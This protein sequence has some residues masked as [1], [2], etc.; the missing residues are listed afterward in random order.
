MIGDYNTI[1]LEFEQLV[2]AYKDCRKHK[3]SSYS[4]MEYECN[5]EVNLVDLYWELKNRIWKP[6]TSIT[7]IVTRPKPREVFA[8]NFRDRIVHHLLIRQIEYLF[9]DVFI[10]DNYNC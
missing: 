5:L 7:F 9:E 10:E 8:A 4:Q 6:G 1:D 2:E 3:R